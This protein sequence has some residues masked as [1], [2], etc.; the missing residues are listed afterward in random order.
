MT[1]NLFQMA[2]KSVQS[3]FGITKKTALPRWCRECEVP[4]ACRGG[5]PKHR[6]VRPDYDEPGLHYLCE[7]YRKFFLYIRKYLRAMTTLLE[8]GLPP[9]YVMEV[10]KGPW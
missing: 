1:D 10:V 2:E 4:A 9:S 7:G 8:Y 3:G 6:F 5:C